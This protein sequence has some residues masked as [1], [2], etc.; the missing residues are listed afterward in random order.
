MAT[1]TP[2][3]QYQSLLAENERI[4]MKIGE[5]EQDRQEHVLVE[6]TLAPLDGS[7]KAYRLVG[8]VLV[9]RTVDEIRPSVLTNRQ[10]V[11][12]SII[13]VACF[14]VDVYKLISDSLTAFRL[15]AGSNNRFS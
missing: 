13:S 4:V 12:L 1:L 14:I 9:E 3:Q 11:L 15:S 8:E 6:Q 2:Q 10:Q 7:R 5:L